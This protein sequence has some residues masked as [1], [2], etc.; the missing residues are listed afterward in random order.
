MAWSL[1]LTVLIEAAQHDVSALEK[2]AQKQRENTHA[3]NLDDGGILASKAGPVDASLPSKAEMLEVAFQK[4]WSSHGSWLRQ[5]FQDAVNF[6]KVSSPRD[7]NILVRELKSPEPGR[8]D[9]AASIKEDFAK[10]VWNSLSN[11]GWKEDRGQHGDRSVYSYKK[12]TVS[13][14]DCSPRNRHILT[15]ATY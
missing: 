2:R 5:V 6:A 7:S 3:A 10:T 12:E 8:D 14:G 11:R 13:S 4:H 15:C 1:V 9:E